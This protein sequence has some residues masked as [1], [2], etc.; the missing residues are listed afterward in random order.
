MQCAQCAAEFVKNGSRQYC[1]N[2]CRNKARRIRKVARAKLVVAVCKFCN[3]EFSYD[4]TDHNHRVRVFCG[5][6]CASK[7]YIQDGTYD[8]WR[9]RSDP[10]MGDYRPCAVCAKVSIYYTESQLSSGQKK[11]CSNKCY[12]KLM[13]DMFSNG[14]GPMCGKK[15]TAEQK[16]KQRDTMMARY[17]I[18]NAYA[19]AKRGVVSKP[20]RWLFEELSKIWD[21]QLEKY[22]PEISCY[23]DILMADKKLIIEFMGD[24]W[25]CNPTMYESSY[26][27]QKKGLTASQIW[28]EDAERRNKIT[29]HGYNLIEVWEA[30]YDKDRVQLLEELKAKINDIGT[31]KE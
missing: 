3:K 4:P 11:V 12:R 14:K 30:D 24:Y 8:T 18:T 26:F 16:Q 23:A 19:L 25:H 20:Q 5:R 22:V 7:H 21:C 2:K 9:L 1:T 27:N 31:K 28:N 10:K 17:G 15:L 6:S 13:S 29:S